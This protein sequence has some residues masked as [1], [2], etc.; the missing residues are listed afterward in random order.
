M[1]NL[2]GKVN[3]MK[4]IGIK[5]IVLSICLCSGV[6]A[7][8]GLHTF[9][10]TDGQSVEA[11][12][13]GY[14]GVKGTVDLKRMNGKRFKVK[15]SVFV[16]DDQKYIQDWSVL[17]GVRDE[18]RFNV[19]FKKVCVEKWSET[20]KDDVSYD[21]GDS[22]KS[23]IGS[24]NYKRYVYE[25]TIGNRNTFPLEDLDVEYRIFYVQDTLN[26]GT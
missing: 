24:S 8:A 4:I 2:K 22:E 23:T 20:L 19:D 11:E 7:R 15:P 26:E 16:E 9:T 17:E 5:I 3:V 13:V 12:I 25:L 1:Y 18:R 6:S 21:G 10:S 14:D